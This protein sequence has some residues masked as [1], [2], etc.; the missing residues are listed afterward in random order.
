MKTPAI[1]EPAVYR[2]DTKVLDQPKSE[3]MGST[4][5]ETE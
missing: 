5:I 1:R 2:P 3:M 4:N